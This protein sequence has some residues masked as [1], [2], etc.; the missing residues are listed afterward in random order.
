MREGDEMVARTFPVIVTATRAADQDRMGCEA[1]TRSGGC[2]PSNA[3]YLLNVAGRGPLPLCG[4]HVRAARL[5]A[6][7]E[8]S[9]CLATRSRYRHPWT[10]AEDAYLRDHPQLRAG[11]AGVYLGR[12]AA[13]VNIRRAALRRE[14]RQ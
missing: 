4:T 11:V 14:G 5:A 3:A 2:C 1:K 12:T 7:G 10:N 13:A 9:R 6:A 8:T